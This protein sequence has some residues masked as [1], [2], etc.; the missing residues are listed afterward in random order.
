LSQRPLPGDTLGNLL[1]LKVEVRLGVA[2][3]EKP[4]VIPVDDSVRELYPGYTQ[5]FGT[6]PFVAG[7]LRPFSRAD[8]MAEINLVGK[9]DRERILSAGLIDIKTHYC[10]RTEDII[11]RVRTCL[12]FRESC[13]SY[14]GEARRF[15]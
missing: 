11:E 1:L 5:A 6:Q 9:W 3:Q 12:E 2:A 10:E 4:N 14:P 15:R 13:F 8:K 7:P